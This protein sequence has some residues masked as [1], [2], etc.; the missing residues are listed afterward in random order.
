MRARLTRLIRRL[1][2]G[3]VYTVAAILVIVGLF[4]VVIE[5][6][7]G[8]RQVLNFV[9]RQAN[10]YLDAAVEIGELSGS[11]FTTLELRDIKLKKD[12]ETIIDIG[13]VALNYRIRE[14]IQDG[15]LIQSVRL[16]RP[17]V[18]GAKHADGRWNLASLVKRQA[19]ERQNTGPRRPIRIESIEV[20]DG[21]V[22][23]KD[24]LRFGAARVPQRYEQLNASLTFD[25]KPVH[26]TIN[27]REISWNGGADDL[28]VQRLAG[29]LG[30]GPDGWMFE[31]LSVRTP[32][33]AFV[34]DGRVERG[35][36]PTVL[37][38]TVGAERFSFQE[39]GVV[40]NGLK[41]IAITA[42]FN[43]H[44][45][46]PLT[47]LVTDL[48]MQSNGGSAKGQI[49]LDTTIPGWHGKGS[50]E[51]AKLD[52][53]PWFSR[54]ARVSHISGRTDFDL[55]LHLG[56]GFPV[57][58]YTFKGP[59]VWYL[60]YDASNINIRGD[61]TERE[62]R[63]AGGT[64]QAYAARVTMDSGSIALASP[65]PFRFTGTARGVDMQLL[66]PSVP[67]PL[68]P[69]ALSF[70]YE[71]VGQFADAFLKGNAWFEQSEFVGSTIGA[72]GVGSIDTSV[73]PIQYS[74]EGDI[75]GIDVARYGRA[76]EVG[77]MLDPRYA[78][79]LSGHFRVDASG[80]SVDTLTL[81]GTGRL[82]E[83]TVFGGA[84]SEAD[85]TIDIEDGTLSG[86]YRGGFRQIDPAIPFAN[87][88][89]TAQLSG[90]GSVQFTIDDLLR[91][92]TALPDYTV[93]GEIELTRSLLSGIEV[94]TGRAVGT[95]ADSTLDLKE[96]AISGP[97]LEG[98]GIGS[99]DFER[100]QIPQFS[101]QLAR[102]DLALAESR[103]G[104]GITGEA[105]SR[106]TVEGP[107]SALA[108]SGDATVTRVSASGIEALTTTGKYR[109]TLPWDDFTA[110][111]V[112][113]NAH[114]SFVQLF[115]Q[116]IRDA[117]WKINYHGKELTYDAALTPDAGPPV[118]L[119]GIV[120]LRLDERAAD[121]RTLDLTIG[122]SAWTLLP[123]AV[124]TELAWNDE[125][126]IINRAV[127]ADA[128]TRQQ[129]V[130]LS[131]SWRSDGKG[132]LRVLASDVFL[133]TLAAAQSD[134]PPDY[135]GLLNLDATIRGTPQRPVASG[136]LTI[137]EG[138]VNRLS[139]QKLAG[140]VGYEDGMLQLDVRL[141]QAPG[142]WLTAKGSV[143]PT[144]LS[145]GGP[146]RPLDL[147]LHSS[148]VGLTL[149]EGLTNRVR[150]VTGEL[151]A[152]VTMTGTTLDPHFAGT[153]EVTNVGFVVAD[154][155]ARYK[156]GLARLD[157]ASDR[158]SVGAF[159]LEDRNGRPIEVTGSLGTH[160]LRVG[161]VE[162]DIRARGLEVLNN[163]SG[164]AAVDTNL[165]IRGTLDAPRLSGSV[166]IV[167]GELR[168]DD[169]LD[170]ALFTPYA[171]VP[172][173]SPVDSPVA[174]LNIWDRL[175]INV[176]VHSQ[177]ALRLTG[178]GVAVSDSPIGLGRFDL[179]ASGDLFVYKDPG[180][181]VAVTGSLD[182]VTGNFSFQ[183][184]RFELYPSSS[185]DF[186][187]DLNP[188]LFLTVYRVISGV[189]ARVTISGPLREPELRLSSNPPLD[190]SE[191]L[192]LIVFNAP[193]NELSAEQQQELA[194][195]AGALAVGFF[196]SAL[197]DALQRTLGLDLLEIEPSTGVDRGAT[198]TVGQEI[199][200]GLVA[201]F[202]RHFGAF[203][204]DE[205]TFEYYISRI[206][207]LRAT[208]SDASGVIA[209]LSAFRRV[210]KV[211]ID[212][213]FFF[214]F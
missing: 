109:A 159:H 100:E 213:L 62:W 2:A 34:L 178:E 14:L 13:A 5:L 127:L 70:R 135:G 120:G 84:L 51:L 78:G 191:V 144:L 77:W 118:A 133:E 96:I 50:V 129:R 106:G 68:V 165:Q 24:P 85:V 41:N 192:S 31:N 39:W 69:S 187:G 80:N 110:A 12:G 148:R 59:Y 150:D 115:G 124:T 179:R 8:K 64:A 136:Q 141:D 157:L 75:R 171:T 214:S 63:I 54:S 194:V 30:N 190:P 25:Y 1:A 184:R 99:I 163:A 183:G 139:Y 19:R 94:T 152:D 142:I 121:L 52:L 164:N 176:S 43:A 177:N 72:G 116:N 203:E 170:R 9:V 90:E 73:T 140:A 67:V 198:V 149:L 87:P 4:L 132:T 32:Q 10:N 112:E 40:L 137:T 209:S 155:G 20:T 35:G 166:S 60:G 55:D 57:G 146:E 23:L 47:A 105:A 93:N 147:E 180:Q 92:T 206:L 22:I 28:T 119:N 200:P 36:K 46:G 37:N 42:G 111:T 11:L 151:L 71:T 108:V 162:I 103:I 3:L 49:V 204:Y 107:F 169:I 29:T 66:P 134:A 126:L 201:R 211:G 74:G 161:D 175:T 123:G 122:K 38:L 207:R 195:R 117:D 45:Q 82:A 16:T 102:A 154:S 197:T 53:A 153:L 173:Q 182:Q 76:L 83:A 181:Q 189:E 156:N 196:A 79:R 205:A 174:A 98:S 168:V 17:Y 193:T 27:F 86:S 188:E 158:V 104:R 145:A 167:R 48:T 44:L 143:P 15:T 125:G 56:R 91:R 199:A 6:P 185:I 202:S 61:I 186:R 113:A 208:F 114:S 138:R 130:E 101:F 212:L 128:A 58:R 81:N 131:G 18:V 160:E 89:L 172:L 97:K 65:Y 21:T 95:L 210:E 26:W 88:Q 7:W 33:S